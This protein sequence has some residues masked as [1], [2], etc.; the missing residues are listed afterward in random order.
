[1]SRFQFVADH[2]A[3]LRGEAAVRA[4]RG[5][6]LLLL[7]LEGRGAGA[8]GPGSSR[9]ASWPSGSGRS[10]T[11][12]NTYG[13][14]RV[15]AELNDGVAPEER[16][17]HKRVARVMRE[18]GIAG[19]QK[20]RA[21]AHHDPRA[22]GPEGPRPAQAG[23]HRP[24]AEPSATSATSPT[25]RW[26]TAEPLPGHRDRLLLTAGWPAGRSPTT[27]A[28]SLVEDAL[29]AAA[30]TRGSLRLPGRSSTA[31]TARSTPRRTTPS[32]APTSASP[33]PWAPSGTSADN[34]L[35][36]SFNATLKREIL[37]DAACWPDEATCRRQVFRWL[38]RY[39]T[40][41]RHS[42]CRYQSPIHLRD[43]LRRYAPVS[44]VIPPRV[45]VPGSRPQ[46]ALVEGHRH[47]AVFT[48]SPL[49]MLQAETCHRG[50]AISRAPDHAV[51]PG[52][53]DQPG[54][55]H[56][57]PPRTTMFRPGSAGARPKHRRRP[58]TSR[59]ETPDPTHP[60]PATKGR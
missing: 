2:R 25:C 8:G 5:R 60:T 11:T 48:N 24:G 9:R 31:T 59:L 1:M 26:P 17:N 58:P 23:L 22:V 50:H 28:P 10:T 37:Q 30:A 44:R 13:A 46:P 53:G 51:D 55:S 19:Y 14:P 38:T 3:H 52:L 18:H 21:G 57:G 36:E 34:A 56:E 49:T 33:S 20:R 35:A 6:P 40:S 41:R 29:K 7:R 42:W 15:T 39:N 12:D 54:F 27:C 16:V 43:P 45:Q 4:R 32:S 47:H